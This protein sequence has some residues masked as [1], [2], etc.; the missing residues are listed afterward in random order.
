M[1]G[2]IV[3]NS[4]QPDVGT[5]LYLDASQGRGNVIIG[6]TT[7][8]LV[9]ISPTGNVTLQGTITANGITSSGNLN[10]S[11]A[12]SATGNITTS[13]N[14]VVSGA[15]SVTGNVSSNNI[16]SSG[17]IN[18]IN[19]FGYKNV[20][21]NGD[22]RIWQRSTSA[23]LTTSSSVYTAADR[24]V[25]YQGT[26]ASGN[27]TRLSS[28]LAG[29]QYIAKV[30]RT[31]SATTTGDMVIGQAVETLNSIPL[32]GQQVTF[33]FWALAGANFSPTSGIAGATVWSG[34]GTDQSFSN[35]TGNLWTGQTT[36]LNSTF[37]PTSSWV[38]YSFTA[39]VPS[40][41]TQLAVA[42][43]WTPTGTAGADDSL[44]ITGMQLE[45]GN[46]ATS[47]D[48]RP[49][50]IELELCQR[51]YEKSFDVGT[52][53]NHGVSAVY[54]FLSNIGSV[55]CAGNTYL[56]IPFKVNKRATG[57]SLRFFDSSASHTQTENWVRVMGSCS[58]GTA[59][60]PNPVMGMNATESYITGYFQ[61]GTAV[62][63]VFEWTAESEL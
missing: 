19:T 62:P 27:F 40:N 28:T 26:S 41:S 47:F 36:V 25:A 5:N 15:L 22:F 37:T 14:V 6:N 20:L 3:T 61:V 34:T 35:A 50:G 2:T 1:A 31:A 48:V 46:I 7:T 10:V 56:L 16:T 11:G 4:V 8:S 54:P 45:R 51:Y 24:F 53:P 59:T 30:Q 38:R 52:A 44:Y 12:L 60:G 17:S 43:Y 63:V 29:F 42:V 49:Y 57:A 9:T 18:S 21:I 39:T 13:S 55:G 23:A 33:S 32:Q 58:S